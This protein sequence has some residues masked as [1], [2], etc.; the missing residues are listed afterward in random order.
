MKL[1]YILYYIFLAVV[2]G[3][4]FGFIGA[5][6][7]LIATAAIVAYLR[8]GRSSVSPASVTP[9][10][11]VQSRDPA[12]EDYLSG[13][14]SRLSRIGFEIRRNVVVGGQGLALY[15]ARNRFELSKLGT[16]RRVIAVFEMDNMTPQ[17]IE[18][19]ASSLM[20]HERDGSLGSSLANQSTFCFTVA[21][22]KSVSDQVI[23]WTENTA[24]K[25]AWKGVSF[26]VAVSLTERRIYRP[27]KTPI[28]GA[29]YYRGLRK[30]ADQ[31]LGF[32]QLP[33]SQSQQSQ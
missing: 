13:V 3:F 12:L 16:A 33:T 8:R 5:L 25:R 20:E 18:G 15:A 10:P 26:P 30:F 22:A 21:V 29:A 11:S 23:G 32:W 27:A 24:G 6:V 17:S 7:V 19:I 28:F 2:A 1:N 31:N 14:S 4:F 9:A